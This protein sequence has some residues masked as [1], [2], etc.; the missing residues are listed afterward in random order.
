M[1]RTE[2]RLRSPVP[3]RGRISLNIC[4]G[5][6]HCMVE[7]CESP[8]AVS[9]PV[10]A[11]AQMQLTEPQQDELERCARSRLVAARAVQRAKIILGLTAGKTKKEIAQQLGIAADRAALGTAFSAARGRGAGGRAALR[12]AARP[13][14]REDRTDRLQDDPGNSFRLHALEHAELGPRGASKCFLGGPD[15]AGARSETAPGE[16]IQTEQ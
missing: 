1:G 10:P 6:W 12:T 3:V 7:R 13:P 4:S 15:L 2:N 16:N 5:I 8:V 11:T 9:N 14:A